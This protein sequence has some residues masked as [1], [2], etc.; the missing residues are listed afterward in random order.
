VTY[1]I[2]AGSHT[3]YVG[4]RENGAQLDKIYLTTGSEMPSGTG[5]APAN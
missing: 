5:G 2:G 4:L 1:N 3:F